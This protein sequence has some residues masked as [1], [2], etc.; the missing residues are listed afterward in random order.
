MHWGMILGMVRK[1]PEIPSPNRGRTFAVR[2]MA[3]LIAVY[4]VYAFFAR[5]VG[6]KLI[7]YYTYSYWSF[8]ESAM[9]FFTDY[10]SIMG[11]F[12]CV[13]YYILKFFQNREKR[14]LTKNI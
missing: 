6:P 4:G 1:I 2:V 11:V 14:G 8:D 10:V 9:F 12:V 5:D 13:T 7:L 3:A